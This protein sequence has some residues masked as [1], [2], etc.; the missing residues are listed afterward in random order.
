M[1]KSRL[2]I[3]DS[4]INCGLQ[5]YSW[6]L[7]IVSIHENQK[8][9]WAICE[10]QKAKISDENGIYQYKSTS[11]HIQEHSLYIAPQLSAT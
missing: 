3:I 9:P 2:G 8:G 10:F 4:I 1:F 7:L 6:N 11:L 5:I